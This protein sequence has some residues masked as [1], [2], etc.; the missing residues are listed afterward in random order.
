MYRTWETG[1]KELDFH[2]E[3]V[4]CVITSPSAN[5]VQATTEELFTDLTQVTDG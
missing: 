3:F 4:Y 5:F 2:F 1:G